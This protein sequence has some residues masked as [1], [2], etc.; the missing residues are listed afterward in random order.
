MVGLSDGCT[1]AGAPLVPVYRYSHSAQYRSVLYLKKVNRLFK[2]C[3]PPARR[4][5][6]LRLPPAPSPAGPTPAI[7]PENVPESLPEILPETE[8]LPE[9]LPEGC[10]LVSSVLSTPAMVLLPPA[11]RVE[12]ALVALLRKE[13]PSVVRLNDG[14]PPCKSSPPDP[15][16]LADTL[17]PDSAS[18]STAGSGEEDEE[19]ESAFLALFSPLLPWPFELSGALMDRGGWNECQGDCS[20]ECGSV[21][22]VTAPTEIAAE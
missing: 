20:F 14:G 5:L 12:F 4:T 16:T 10:L 7:L 15:G 17:L 11:R 2:L 9:I 19:E 22:L 13:T 18:K 1:H 8:I 21:P 3:P 6:L